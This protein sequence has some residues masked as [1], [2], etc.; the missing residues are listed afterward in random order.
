MNNSISDKKTIGLTPEGEKI[1]KEI[2]SLDIFKDMIDSAK[3]AMSLAINAGIELSHT[4]KAN[5]IWNVGSF[6]SDNQLRQMI[7]ILYP[8]CNTPYRAVESLIDGGLLIIKSKISGGSLD[9]ALLI[10]QEEN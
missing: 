10:Q 1:M 9:V 7:P 6:D 5:T 4:E 8:N 3:F 2:M